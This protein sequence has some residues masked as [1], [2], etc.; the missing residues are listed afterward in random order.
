MEVTALRRF[1]HN[2]RR[3]VGE[4]FEVS[5]PVG[6]ELIR[7]GLVREGAIPANPTPTAGARPSASPADPV[8]LQTTAPPSKRGGR[9]K[10]AE[11]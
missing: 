5:D 11:A 1:V 4:K 9:K 10:K 7:R 6:R 8:S 2:G 3:V